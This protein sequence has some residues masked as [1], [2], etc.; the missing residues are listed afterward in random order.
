MRVS[1]VLRDPFKVATG[2]RQGYI[3]SPLLFSVCIN[4]I[5]EKLRETKVDVRCR[6]EHVPTLLF[7]DDMMILAEGEEEL[8][9][10]LGILEEWCSEWAMKVN[11]DK[12]SVMHIRRNGV[13]RTT[14]IFSVGGERVKA[15]ESYKYLGCIV[16]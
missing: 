14:S 16:N 6:E 2:L 5:V 11:A 10:E 13:K 15:V 8:R 1:N 12:C 4:G 7:A 9:R 3:L